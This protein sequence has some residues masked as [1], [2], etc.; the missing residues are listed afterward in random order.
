MTSWEPW[1]LFWL[2]AFQ[3]TAAL[4]YRE[5]PHIAQTKNWVIALFALNG[6]ATLAIGLATISSIAPLSA[7]AE[8]VDIWT[9]LALLGVAFALL[10]VGTTRWAAAAVGILGLF[11]VAPTVGVL[12]SGAVPLAAPV[13]DFAREL[14]LLAAILVTSVVL[15]RALRAFDSATAL[16]AGVLG[17]RFA[18]L[19]VSTFTVRFLRDA[20]TGQ[21]ATVATDVLRAS[22]TISL[23]LVAIVLIVA[24]RKVREEDRAIHDLVTGLLGAG[25]MIGVA[26]VQVPT[27]ATLLYFT[28]AFIRPLAFLAAQSRLGGHGLFGDHRW[29]SARN[30]ALAGVVGSVGLFAASYLWLLP[31]A[32][33]TM[34]AAAV[35]L[36]SYLA[37]R[38]MFPTVS[39]PPAHEAE[40]TASPARGSSPGEISPLNHRLALL[41]YWERLV[42]VLYAWR[43]QPPDA[44]ERSTPALARITGV[45]AASIGTEVSR[46]N[47]RL[48]R[49]ETG[50]ESVFV[51][52][53]GRPTGPSRRPVKVYRLTRT[54]ETL[55]KG[56]MARIG[57]ATE[58]LAELRT[59]TVREIVPA[60]QEVDLSTIEP[61]KASDS[62][63]ALGEPSRP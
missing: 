56:I 8:A 31:T 46:T 17:M 1:A 7:L 63:S 53:W 13:L 16:V 19:T 42:V 6:A 59:A 32:P 57:M 24:R 10:G 35:A 25:F 30:M 40:P 48:E 37:G 49:A 2:A 21:F 38:A 28:V 23:V 11:L 15:L 29:K 45:P 18:E 27:S 12:T 52:S 9:N 54:G 47:E 4:W 26:R 22:A 41:S 33:A 61:S 51:S 50:P 39:E 44:P 3:F 34:V 43:D 55:A 20:F 14:P 58:D 60:D 5:G 62:E 36:L